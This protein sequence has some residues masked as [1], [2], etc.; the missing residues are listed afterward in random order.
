MGKSLEDLIAETNSESCWSV[1]H[2][3]P[4]CPPE[5]YTLK[6]RM[7]FLRVNPHAFDPWYANDPEPPLWLL[8]LLAML[9]MG[10]PFDF[11]EEPTQRIQPKVSQVHP[12]YFWKKKKPRSMKHHRCRHGQS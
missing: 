5:A 11:L 7:E 8:K 1:I 10:I 9:S 3:Q 2:A 4:M 6:Q 12:H